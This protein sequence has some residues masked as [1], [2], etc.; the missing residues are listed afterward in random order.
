MSAIEWIN[1][2]HPCLEE[3]DTVEVALQ[4]FK[5]LQGYTELALRTTDGRFGG[6]FVPT[7]LPEHVISQALAC[8]YC[9]AQRARVDAE[10]SHYEVLRASQLHQGMSIA[11]TDTANLYI[12]TISPQDIVIG[13]A[14]FAAL[15]S[16]GTALILR[17][18]QNN[19]TLSELSQIVESH[20]AKILDLSLIQDAKRPQDIL[21]VLKLSSQDSS[22]IRVTLERYGYTILQ[23]RSTSDVLDHKEK[24]N[25]EA[26]MKYLSL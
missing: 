15:R 23:H 20:S 26:L 11:V 21:L 2:K 7:Q 10:A 1:T 17:M 24:K 18:R 14:L 22:S 13:M 8:D 6:F 12:G 3:T 16:P 19:Y 4:Q 25:Y 5:A 9:V